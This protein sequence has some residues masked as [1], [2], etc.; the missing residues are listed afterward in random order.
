ML[1]ARAPG[2]KFLARHV[3]F[4]Q[5]M[6]SL[7]TAKW[8]LIGGA[9]AYAYALHNQRAQRARP[10]RVA[11]ADQD[12]MGSDDLDGDLGADPRDPVQ[13]FDEMPE[14]GGPLDFDAMS[15]AD[16]EAAS[17]LAGLESEL[18]GDSMQIDAMDDS[19]AIAIAQTMGASGSGEL[20][21]L[22]TPRAEHGTLPD[23]DESM[24]DGQTWLEALETS[25]IENGAVAGQELDIIDDADL[26]RGS[27]RSMR[28]DRPIA[29]LGSA[30]PR[31]M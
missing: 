12:L 13:G 1:A 25:A 8:L 5:R 22:H 28:D 16:A 4:V 14:L 24:S 23:D 31:G 29:D 30:G 6:M 17:D 11:D 26:E 21:G 20:Y 7:R 2:P 19:T 27:H 10:R 3:L 15:A 9:V 18:D